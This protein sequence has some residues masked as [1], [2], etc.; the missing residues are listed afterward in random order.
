MPSSNYVNQYYILASSAVFYY[1]FI[2]T[3]P[4]EFKNLWTSKLKAVNVIVI[5]LRY[6]TALG[7]VLVLMLAF[8]P[9]IDVKTLA[10]GYTTMVSSEIPVF[11][12]G[13][14]EV[15]TTSCF[16]ELLLGP[17]KST[18]IFKASYIT[19]ILFDTLVFVLAAIKTGRMYSVSKMYR[20]TPSIVAVLLRDGSLLYAILTISN[21]TNFVLFEHFIDGTEVQV[22]R[23]TVGFVVSSGTN[24]ELTHA[25]SVIFISRMVFNLR[26]VGTEVCE[27]TT[28][29]RAR[30][31]PEFSTIQLHVPTS[32]DVSFEKPDSRCLIHVD[33]EIHNS[34]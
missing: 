27:G 32:P 30:I 28:Q 13:I 18:K 22:V 24:S 1:D 15:I 8:A 20:A 29:W 26:E 3:L 5:A 12:E 33:V 2:L 19:T 9:V 25:L 34:A 11:K 23:T 21:L 7:Y 17:N 14:G 10:L 31:E 16:A 4:Q 6:I